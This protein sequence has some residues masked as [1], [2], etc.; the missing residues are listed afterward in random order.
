MDLL[1]QEMRDVCK[2]SSESLDSPRRQQEKE[3]GERYEG[4]GTCA[5]SPFELC[6]L[7]NFLQILGGGLG[8]LVE[9]GVPSF[10]PLCRL[11]ALVVLRDFSVR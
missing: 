9:R 10:L 4:E 7:A 5:V 2:G 8:V 6:R 1:C 11:V 3:V